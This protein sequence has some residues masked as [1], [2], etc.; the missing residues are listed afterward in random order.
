MKKAFEN[1]TG[2]GCASKQHFLLF[3]HFKSHFLLVYVTLNLL[4]ANDSILD[5]CKILLIVQESSLFSIAG[6]YPLE[7]ADHIMYMSTS[8]IQ[9]MHTYI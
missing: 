5:Q 4:S 9:I 3:P 7:T 2:K 1:I 8:I 6:F